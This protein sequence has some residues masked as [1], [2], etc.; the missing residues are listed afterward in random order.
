[1][2][3]LGQRWTHYL[4]PAVVLVITTGFLIMTYHLPPAARAMPLLVGWAA[5]AFSII[6]LVSRNGNNF[7]KV[8]MR[9]LNPAGL[10]TAL[11]EQAEASAGRG[12]LLTG[13][14]LVL[15]LVVAFILVGVL[16]AAPVMIFTALMIA[17]RRQLVSNLVI[18]AVATGVIWILF[19][20]LLRLQLYPGVLFGGTF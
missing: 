9:A 19:S 4:P 7:G 13:I 17:Y 6:D 14:G 8:L 1:M 11:E 3:I 12:A 20:V 18:A 2:T 16:V 5:L 10:T 15:L